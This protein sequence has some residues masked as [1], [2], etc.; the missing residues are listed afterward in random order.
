MLTKKWNQ[1]SLS[2]REGCHTLLTRSEICILVNKIFQVSFKKKGEK[3]ILIK[4][5]DIGF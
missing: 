4:I 5:S 1:Q 3:F 2:N